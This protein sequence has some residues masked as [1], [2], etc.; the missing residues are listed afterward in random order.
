MKLN[1]HRNQTSVLSSNIRWQTQTNHEKK[2][3]CLL[4]ITTQSCYTSRTGT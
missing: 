3:R 4:Y 2:S 1:R